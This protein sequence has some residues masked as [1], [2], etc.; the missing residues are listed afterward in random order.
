MADLQG[1]NIE[2]RNNGQESKAING[3][4]FLRKDTY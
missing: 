3:K 1:L 2:H 4:K